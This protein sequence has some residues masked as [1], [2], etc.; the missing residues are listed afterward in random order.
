MKRIYFLLIFI[1]VVSCTPLLNV[2]TA[3]DAKQ[4]WQQHKRIAII[5]LR[6]I[7]RDND[8]LKREEYQLEMENMMKLSFSIQNNI[9]RVL[10]NQYN[11]SNL[12][13]TIM[14][15]DS[16]TKILAKS[17][18]RYSTLPA[19]NIEK[20]CAL[21][22]VDAVIAGEVEF[23]SPA[24]SL[25]GNAP[26]TIPGIEKAKLRLNI[27]D[28]NYSSP[29]WTFKEV[30]TAREYNEY[31]KRSGYI[32]GTNEEYLIAYMFDKAMKIL[33]YVIKSPVKRDY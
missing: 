25:T 10:Q 5:P 31:Y 33:P 26:Y 14:P 12:S 29:I 15:V 6:V 30:N 19:K 32:N 20:I 23:Y 16:T 22:K 9:Y 4:L 2:T 1:T 17:N 27:Y 8:M 24:H 18:I 7:S 11:L 3:R 21:L 28:K 13:V